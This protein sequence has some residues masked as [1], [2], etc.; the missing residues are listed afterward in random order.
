MARF[1]AAVMDGAADAKF[2]N[3]YN[4]LLDLLDM[5]YIVEK[6]I[7]GVPIKIE[8]SP[9]VG[10]AFY[11]GGG[12]TGWVYRGGLALVDGELSL[13]TDIMKDPDSTYP[14]M[15]FNDTTD[16]FASFE[17]ELY[18]ANAYINP[19]G[20]V[21][22]GSLKAMYQA[23]GEYGASNEHAT[24]SLVSIQPTGDYAT[25]YMEAA[26]VDYTAYAGAKFDAG[27]PMYPTATLN[28]VKYNAGTAALQLNSAL[29]KGTYITENNWAGSYCKLGVSYN[30]G[31]W[32]TTNNVN[33]H[34]IWHAGNDGSGSGLSADDVDGVHFALLTGTQSSVLNTAVTVALPSG[35]TYTNSYIVS[36]MQYNDSVAYWYQ[37]STNG[38]YCF[39]EDGLLSVSTSE[40]FF[41]SQDFKVLIGRL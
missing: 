40:S 20:S 29:N 26:D 38:M 21:K 41:L 23:I 32:V 35:F 16:V 27:D 13:L 34:K 24:V 4:Y 30:D 22:A 8:M 15:K 9:N 14:Y 33:Y 31:A 17:L 5:G 1:N 39:F 18:T 10:L 28:A 3:R 19:T 37:G 2:Q 25:V 12:P 36:A 7:N 11:Q 6:R